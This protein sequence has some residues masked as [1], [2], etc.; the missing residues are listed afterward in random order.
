MP[1]TWRQASRRGVC[2]DAQLETQERVCVSSRSHTDL[3][4]LNTAITRV[5]MSARTCHS[6]H[7]HECML[8]C[9]LACDQ[10]STNWC[11]PTAHVDVL[12]AS[13]QR[14]VK[15]MMP[16]AC[17]AAGYSAVA[18]Q[19]SAD[20]TRTHLAPAK[21]VMSF[22]LSTLQHRKGSSERLH[23]RL[24]LFYIPCRHIMPCELETA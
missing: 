20:N 24:R 4:A 13:Q 9:V 17:F 12:L 5:C 7:L 18:A 14:L 6:A 1:L 8:E 19:C 22:L 21:L 11:M 2:E 3:A 16:A 15:G 23:S 10:A